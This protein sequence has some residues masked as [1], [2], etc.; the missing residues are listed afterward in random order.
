MHSGYGRMFDGAGLQSCCNDF[1]RN[2][3]TCDVD[4]SSSHTNNRSINFLVLG[5]EPTDNINESIGATEHIL[6]L[7]LVKKER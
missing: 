7:I 1:A 3:V 2:V 5:E 4:N 6:M